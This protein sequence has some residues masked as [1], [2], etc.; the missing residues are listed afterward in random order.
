M[1]LDFADIKIVSLEDE[2]TVASPT[3][4][5]LSYIYFRLSQTPPPLW[6][7]HFK[8]SRKIARNARWR[9][10][11]IDRRFLVMECTS[12]EVEANL[13]EVKKDLAHANH[14]YRQYLTHHL[15]SEQHKEKFRGQQLDKLREMK[16]RLNFD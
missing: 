16:G 15:A 10:L 7:N 12:E 6:T 2:M 9:H 3:Y 11:W 5:A 14:Q 4:P 8:E 1:E 13:Q